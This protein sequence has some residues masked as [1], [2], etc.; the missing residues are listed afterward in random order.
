MDAQY[1][2][3]TSDPDSYI[4]K[5]ARGDPVTFAEQ[6]LRN[7][8]SEPMRFDG[9]HTFQVQYMRDFA[10]EIYVIKSSQQGITTTTV[11]KT[12]YLMHLDSPR[13]FERFG[14]HGMHGLTIIYTFPTATDVREFS[15]TRF[16]KMLASSHY[17]RT[18]MKNKDDADAVEVRQLGHSTIFFRGSFTERQAIS[19][20]ADLIVND[21]LDFSDQVVVDALNSR[22]TASQLQWRWKFSTPTIPNYGI[23]ALYKQSN[24]YRWLVECPRCGRDQQIKFP[25]NVR[26]KK[27]R[28]VRITYFGCTYCGRELP[29]EDGRWVSRYPLRRAHGYFMP[30]TIAPWI[31][32]LTI[33]KMR[34]N[35]RN[36]KQFFNY[37]MGEAYSTGVDLLTR[38]LL[39]KR[40][41]FGEPYNPEMDRMTYM[42][43]DQ[44]DVL[45]YEVSRGVGGRRELIETG[46]RTTFED[47]GVLMNKYNIKMCVMD[48]MP[49]K[50]PA[51]KFAKDFFGRVKLATY[52]QEFDDD[53][54]VRDSKTVT[55]GI[56]VDRTNALDSST[57]SWI[58]GESWYHLDKYE[59]SR[60]PQTV[61][62]PKDKNSWTSQMGNMTRDEIENKKTGKSRAEWVKTGP[63]H[64]RHADSYNYI[65]WKI[66]QSVR[67]EFGT[68]NFKR[69][70]SV[71]T[72]S[73]AEL[74]MMS[75]M[76]NQQRTSTFESPF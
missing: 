46:T 3:M 75:R 45:H 26:R 33:V 50:K 18:E 41:I 74:D 21:E 43:V 35:Y 17:L 58:E 49:N 7:E 14:A 12:L 63:E 20:P 16:K 8:K 13:D 53:G 39:L 59:F 42:G 31:Q 72:S 48:M 40:I 47:I 29:R 6:N 9:A 71:L 1:D 2:L 68:D 27:V 76:I 73:P 57:A 61:D 11:D 25:Q 60:I 67:S 34:S 44:G 37:G 62:D 22:L 19:V 54:D 64:F 52:K 38:D 5:V 55:H 56:N 15:K 36:D 24:Q 30:P 28:G 32:P 23:D 65:A 4:K 66:H 69:E 51:E 10:P 70:N